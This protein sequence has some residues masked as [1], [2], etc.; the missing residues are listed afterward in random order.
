M[1]FTPKLS[2]GKISFGNKPPKNPFFEFFKDLVYAGLESFGRYYSTYRAYVEENE[3]PLH[4][5]RLILIIP[6]V[7]GMEPY[8]YWAFPKNNYAGNGYGMQLLPR[9]GDVVWVEFESGK[10]EYPIWQHGYFALG[11]RPDD[12]KEL[13]DTQCYWLVTPN[14]I[15][16]KLNDT[17]DTITIQNNAK[18]Q[19]IINPNGVS[20]ISEKSISLGQ[21]DKSQEPGVL[22]NTADRLLAEFTQDLGKLMAINTSSGIT[23][24]INS[25]ANWSSFS[26]KWGVQDKNWAEFKSKKITL[27]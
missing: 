27:D 15:R 1:S 7:T 26:Q 2:R 13:D 11:E 20:V 3:D 17:K 12:D 8:N 16:I 22:G 6:T 19:V 23:G 5:N 14:G 21:L 25:A 24:K 10:P 18:N 9:K 4:L